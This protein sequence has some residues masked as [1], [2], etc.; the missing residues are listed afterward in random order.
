M[1]DLRQIV[2]DTETTGLSPDNDRVVEI[3]CVEVINRRLTHVNFHEY[4]NP[5]MPMPQGA[6]D[7][8][9]LSDEF[10]SDKPLFASVCA[11]FLEYVKGSQLIIHN[12]SF[13]RNASP[14]PE[15]G[16]VNRLL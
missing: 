4:L 6:F 7:V 1:S 9:G 12:A 10:L 2:L 16:N 14:R 15:F 8:H 11:S 3:G 5:Q 13:D